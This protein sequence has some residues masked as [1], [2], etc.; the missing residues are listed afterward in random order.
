M[1]G[2]LPIGNNIDVWVKQLIA[3]SSINASH[4]TGI[5]IT[6]ATIVFSIYDLT[7]SAYLCQNVSMPLI[8]AGIAHY[9]GS[10]GSLSIV[11]GQAYNITIA[12][13]NY[14]FTCEQQFVGGIRPFVPLP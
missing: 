11:E 9:R 12:C 1:I 6:N 7:N 10:V 4:P 2:Y 3:S 14:P 8:D 5:L 13:S